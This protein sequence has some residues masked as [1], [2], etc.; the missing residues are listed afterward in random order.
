MIVLWHGHIRCGRRIGRH[1]L[2]FRGLSGQLVQ[3]DGHIVF[4]ILEHAKERL[5]S[6]VRIA[7]PQY[8]MNMAALGRSSLKAGKIASSPTATSYSFLHVSIA[9]C[10]NTVSRDDDMEC[11]AA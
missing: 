1:A 10:T 4:F 8:A 3:R 11:A 7:R 5:H 9:G 6:M 2:P